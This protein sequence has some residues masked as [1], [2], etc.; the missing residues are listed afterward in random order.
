MKKNELVTGEKACEVILEELKK[1]GIDIKQ[2]IFLKVWNKCIGVG[3]CGYNKVRLDPDNSKEKI[4][5]MAA[6]RLMLILEPLILPYKSYLEIYEAIGYELKPVDEYIL[7]DN[8]KILAKNVLEGKIKKAEEKSEENYL[9]LLDLDLDALIDRAI[10]ILAGDSWD[11]NS[12]NFDSLIEILESPETPLLNKEL[13]AEKFNGDINKLPLRV[14]FFIALEKR[15]FS[16]EIIP[17]NWTAVDYPFLAEVMA[18]DETDEV[19]ARESIRLIIAK[20]MAP[21]DPD[22]PVNE[23]LLEAIEDD[24]NSEKL[25]EEIVKKMKK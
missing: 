8:L 6:E 18:S 21:W 15:Q 3:G 2:E 13:I 16:P 11:E 5:E 1:Q 12:E 19:G 25:Q 20:K 7:K 14:K 23:K 22:D 10:K 17:D 9:D 4:S 24:M